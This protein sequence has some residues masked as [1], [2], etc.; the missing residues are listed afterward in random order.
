MHIFAAV[1]PIALL[2][3]IIRHRHGS[4]A[5]FGALMS[6]YG[7]GAILTAVFLLP[8]M[9]ARFSFDK[10]LTA[11]C[12]CSAG[13]AALLAFAPNSIATGAIL[14]LGGAGWISGLNTLSVAAQS[15][16]PNWVRAR[17]SAIYLV[18]AQGALALGAL[19]WGRMTTDFGATA[20]LCTAACVG[21]V[22]FAKIRDRQSLRAA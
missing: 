21:R 6:C 13:S 22:V 18:T 7:A 4:G 19:A 9:R 5:E 10:V 16:F 8:K 20:A 15:A 11:A 2:P 14:L 17:S 12:L 3:V 1:A